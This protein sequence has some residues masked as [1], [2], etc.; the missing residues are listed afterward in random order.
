[1]SGCAWLTVVEIKSDVTMKHALSIVRCRCC[2]LVARDVNTSKRDPTSE[3]LKAKGAN[4]YVESHDISIS[5]DEQCMN[6]LVV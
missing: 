3:A 2:C 6:N 1:M 4:C 5:L